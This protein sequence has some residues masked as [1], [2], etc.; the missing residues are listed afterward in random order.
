MSELSNF[1]GR[2]I[3]KESIE[4]YVMH[5]VMAESEEGVVFVL[6]V[7]AQDPLNAIEIA[8]YVKQ[9]EGWRVKQ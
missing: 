9:E 5:E 8:K 1:M 6:N 2:C 7:V 4:E 3:D